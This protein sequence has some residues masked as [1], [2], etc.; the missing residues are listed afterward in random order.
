[1]NVAIVSDIHSNL[2]ALT[3]VMADIEGQ[4]I[5]RIL[6]LGD[7]IGCATRP[8]EPSLQRWRRNTPH[9]RRWTT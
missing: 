8:H 6:C 1:M 2:E 3:T 9:T 7:V 4:G 5:T